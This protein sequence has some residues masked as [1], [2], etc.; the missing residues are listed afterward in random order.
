MQ[1]IHVMRA[2]A[3]IAKLHELLLVS[4]PIMDTQNK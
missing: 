4:Q 2:R 3:C 1:A